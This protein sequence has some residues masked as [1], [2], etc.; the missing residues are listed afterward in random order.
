M[1]IE[2]VAGARSDFMKIASLLRAIDKQNTCA[3]AGRIMSILSK[4]R[5]KTCEKGALQ[6]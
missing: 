5:P 3:E 2:L 1:K 6:C 4:D